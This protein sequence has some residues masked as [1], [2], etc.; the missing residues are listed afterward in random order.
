MV[1]G[2]SAE[3]AEQLGSGNM[4]Q[5]EAALDE[6]AEQYAGDWAMEEEQ[7]G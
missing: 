3:L 6:V 4:G 1:V 2:R 7:V 5:V